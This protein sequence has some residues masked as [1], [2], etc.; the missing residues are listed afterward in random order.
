MKKII[1]DGDPGH[2]DA[3]ALILALASNDLEVMAVTTVGGNNTVENTTK[4]ALKVLEVCN[5][6]DIPVAAGRSKP[7]YNDLTIS[8]EVHGK[9]GMDGP[10]L[11]EPTLKIA[12]LNAVELM[13]KIVEESDEKITLVAVGPFSNIGLFLL[14]YPH[15]KQKIECISVMG[16]GVQEGNRTACAE[17]NIW[18]DPEAAQ[19]VFESGIP[20]ILHGLNATRKA[21]ITREEFELFRNAGNKVSTFVAD[22]LDFF[23]L[24]CIDERKFKGCLM[25]DSCAIMSLIHPEIFDY[26]DAHVSIELDGRIT[27]GSCIVDSRTELAITNNCRIASDVDRVEF[28][29]YLLEACEVVANG[30]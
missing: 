11:P 28:L 2:D 22:L 9:S 24:A 26:F 8:I 27:R 7:L 23:A 5:R 20:I 13:A 10:V 15:L 3:I 14:C 16:G 29:K 17:F 19:V 21:Y 25:H 30:A 18:N 12:S 1:F 4:N 6:L